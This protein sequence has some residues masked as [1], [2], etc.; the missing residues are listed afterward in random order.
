MDIIIV[1]NAGADYQSRLFID[2]IGNMDIT[3]Y[4]ADSIAIIL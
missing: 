3:R 1:W 4:F 2:H